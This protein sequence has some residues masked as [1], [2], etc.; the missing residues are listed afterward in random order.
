[1]HTRAIFS[2]AHNNGGLLPDAHLLLVR[3]RQLISNCIKGPLV[4]AFRSPLMKALLPMAWIPEA[5]SAQMILV[6]YTLLFP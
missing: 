2:N 4:A 5:L 1:M 6:S 3:K